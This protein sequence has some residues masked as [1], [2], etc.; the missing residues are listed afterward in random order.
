MRVHPG[1]V[2]DPRRT[3]LLRLARGLAVGL[4]ALTALG[5]P[6]PAHAIACGDTLGPRGSAVLDGDLACAVSPA[7]TIVGPFTLNLHGSTI[8]CIEGNAGTGTGIEV[9][10]IGARV[11]DGTVA[12]CAKGVVVEGNG[13]HELKQLSVTSPN[14]TGDD[15]IGFQ[16][17]SDRNRFVEDA[18]TDYAGEG[19]RLGDDGVP[20][21]RNALIHNEATGNANHGFRVRIGQH[22]LLLLNS[23][24]HNAAEGFRA[25]DGGNRFIAN[26][27]VGN[28]DEGFRVRDEPAQSNLLLGNTAEDNGLE[29]CTLSG[30]NPDANPGIAIVDDAA[31]NQIRNNI[32]EGNCV[33]IVVGPGS[34]NNRVIKNTA[35]GSRL[36]DLADGNLDCDDNTWR[37]NDF[38]TSAAGPDFSE[39]SPECIR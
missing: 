27:A 18:V 24:D 26:T 7:L 30:D 33:G 34:L 4:G 29:P 25:Q 1:S 9:T 28:G 2:R 35:L 13:R 5:S 10:G 15:G 36:V 38:D 6:A 3:F 8:S 23:A 31:N 12:D 20:A 32:A 39:T 17:K 37:R 21:N 16:V 11:R 19:F 14:V 22:N